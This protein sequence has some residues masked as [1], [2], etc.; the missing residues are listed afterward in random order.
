MSVD[1]IVQA[2]PKA[3]HA[4]STP[5]QLVPLPTPTSAPTL[6]ASSASSDT[7]AQAKRA[8]QAVYHTPELLHRILVLLDK[9]VLAAMLTLHKACSAPVAAVLFRTV[10]QKQVKG[11]NRADVSTV[12]PLACAFVPRC[13]NS[14]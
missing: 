9:C 1:M 11:M 12:E 7:P 10:N 13:R 8:A 5:P 3:A 14:S 6:P 2:A 4:K